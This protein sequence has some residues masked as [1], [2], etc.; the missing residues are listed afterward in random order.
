MVT[1]D[2]T[3][4][5]PAAAARAKPTGVSGSPTLIRFDVEG[6]ETDRTHFLAPDKMLAWLRAGE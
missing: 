5:S 2:L 6:K 4:H 1:I 3:D